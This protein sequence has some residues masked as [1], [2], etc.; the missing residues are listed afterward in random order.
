MTYDNQQPAARQNKARE[1]RPSML[2]AFSLTFSNVST[3]SR[4]SD[5]V[6]EESR[7]G[8]QTNE[9]LDVIANRVGSVAG[10]A[11]TVAA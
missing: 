10:N 9:K 2:P 5:G 8:Q 3:A 4:Q 11:P 1:G 6:L 7:G